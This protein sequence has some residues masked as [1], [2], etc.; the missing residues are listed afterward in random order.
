MR[1]LLAA[2]LLLAAGA[3]LADDAEEAAL[4]LADK[5]ASVAVRAS[6]WRVLTEGALL[7]S[8]S[9]ADGAYR[10]AQ[11]LS[12]DVAYD[13]K[14]SPEWR[15]LFAD[16]LD[17]TWSGRPT[18][19]D[20]VNTLKEAYVSWQ[21]RADR[22]LDVGRVNLRLGVATGYNPTDYFRTDAVR[23]VVSI[24]PA[25]LRENRLGT[26]MVRGQ[27][28]WSSGSFSALYAPALADGPNSSPFSPDLGATNNRNRW[29]LSLSQK[30]GPTFTPQFLLYGEDGSS[31]QLGLNATALL[32]KATVVFVES[33]AGR[34]RSQL[35][36]AL[37]LPDDSAL[38][39]RLAAGATYTTPFKL[40]LT[41]EYEHN[42]AG[43]NRAGWDAL[44]QGPPAAYQTYR[45][46][47]QSK[48]DLPTKNNLFFY[49]VWQDV[50]IP[51]LD[52]SAMYRFDAIDH[53]SLSWAELRYHWDRVELALQWQ[54]NRGDAGSQFGAL[55]DEQIWQALVTYFF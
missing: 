28:L 2:I 50:L 31:P 20:L 30:L 12:L 32:G 38:R 8:M 25:S 13:K 19:D 1:S 43:L 3:A 45:N 11:R 26:V 23:S 41:L 7:E 24:N 4:Q 18:Y 16:R 52:L 39:A 15:L 47:V 17:L 36:Q 6:D 42:G 9:R 53:S 40:S 49:A 33:S 35:A 46:F 29:L 51:K 5:T 10:H 14:L 22:M 54:Y 21:P 37:G 48:Q 27:Q 34:Q 55:P 44:R